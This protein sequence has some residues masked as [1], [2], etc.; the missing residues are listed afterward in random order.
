MD[1]ASPCKAK[2]ASL[3]IFT[4]MCPRGVA[5]SRLGERMSIM[6]HR[7]KMAGT[8]PP[9]SMSLGYDDPL[10]FPQVLY[11]N[12]RNLCFLLTGRVVGRDK[13]NV[14]QRETFPAEAK[15]LTILLRALPGLSA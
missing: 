4:Y 13:Q 9:L 15:G 8:A 5:R 1:V 7:E 14:C 2:T 6:H 12:S 3:R 10:P 11:M